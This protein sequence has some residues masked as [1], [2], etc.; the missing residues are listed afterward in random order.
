MPSEDVEPLT[1]VCPTC[2]GTGI[3]S[4]YWGEIVHGNWGRLKVDGEHDLDL[5]PGGQFYGGSAHHQC[6]TCRGSGHA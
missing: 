2:L 1:A 6:R 4:T 3:Q 5:P